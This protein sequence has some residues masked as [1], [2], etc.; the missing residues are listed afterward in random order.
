[1][2]NSGNS[3]QPLLE[4]NAKRH[5][6]AG[7][8]A[9]ALVSLSLLMTLAAQPAHA[10]PVP[11]SKIAADMWQVVLSPTTPRLSWAKDVNGVRMVK[12]LI[13]SN[14]TD[15]DLTALR[16]DVI[17]KGGAVYFRYTSVAALSVMLPSWTVPIIALRSDVQGISPNR[18]TAR[19]AST[20]EAV[21]GAIN[22]RTYTS[23]TTT[24]GKK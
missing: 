14:S 17:A 8:L 13:V 4:P 2:T 24:R 23:T 20:L 22:L 19:T 11:A 21:T 12:A 7:L 5:G 16:A 3:T 18:L 6:A 9:M 1:M 15:P 10:E